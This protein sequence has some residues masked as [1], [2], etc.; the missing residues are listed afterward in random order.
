[1]TSVTGF[2]SCFIA[3]MHAH[4]SCVTLHRIARIKILFGRQVLVNR[5]CDLDLQA[6][7]R[8]WSHSALS[9]KYPE[10]YYGIQKPCF[11][12]QSLFTAGDGVVH[13]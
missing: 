2:P 3:I 13:I 5:C 4:R 8:I 7:R 12:E 10:L 1:M 11:M 6:S 9:Y